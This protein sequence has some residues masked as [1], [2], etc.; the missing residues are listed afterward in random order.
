MNEG[1]TF[2][3]ASWAK[4]ENR[5]RNWCSLHG[6]HKLPAGSVFEAFPAR[7]ANKI[8]TPACLG[9]LNRDFSTLWQNNDV[10]SSTGEELRVHDSRSFSALPGNPSWNLEEDSTS[11]AYPGER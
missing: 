4:R 2:L 6:S 3:L 1:S 8:E 10:W 7:V 5:G 11:S 9:C